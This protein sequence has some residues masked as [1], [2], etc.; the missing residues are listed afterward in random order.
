MG[1]RQTACRACAAVKT[2][3][4]Q[5]VP[6]TRCKRLS[7]PCSLGDP[8]LSSPLPP[9]GRDD[10]EAAPAPAPGSR[11]AGLRARHSK[12]KSVCSNCR[13][14][15]KKC[16]ERRP[17]CSDC[18]RLGLSCSMRS[19]QHP[20]ES[21]PPQ[22][23]RHKTGFS[24]RDYEIDMA[25]AADPALD[26][27]DFDWLSVI[28]E[29]CRADSTAAA[30]SLAHSSALQVQ[31]PQQAAPTGLAAARSAI[32][33]TASA[34]LAGI[35]PALL[36]GWEVGE[37]HLLNHFLQ[38]V[39]RSLTLVSD[40]ENPL[41]C[42]VVPLALANAAMRHALVAL[43]ACHL[44]RTYPNFE[45]DMLRHRSLALQ[46]LEAEL[47]LDGQRRTVLPLAA[48]LLLC[49]LEICAG[50]SRRWLLYL[51]GARALLCGDIP[52]A[53]ERAMELLID[54]HDYLC[55][56]AAV[57]SENVPRPFFPS[58]GLLKP[59]KSGIHPL[60]G[61]AAGLYAILA[62]INQFGIRHHQLTS[63][64]RQSS[65]RELKAEA[66]SI[67]QA[68]EDW[69]PTRDQQGDVKSLSQDMAEARAVASAVQCAAKLLLHDLSR[70]DA[71]GEETSS[72]QKTQGLVDNILSALAFIRPGS[73]MNARMLFPL[74]T[75]GLFSTS[76]AHRLT[77]EFRV[78]LLNASLGFGSIAG[79][80][81]T[82]NV[83]WA[84]A[85][86]GE[87]CQ[88]RESMRSTAPGTVLL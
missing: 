41:I 40:E 29:E 68:L 52:T 67:E 59:G 20:A 38:S 19:E 46:A 23:P 49:L 21:S 75:A 71:E 77:L 83:V 27:P 36:E 61:I 30:T 37:V 53:D 5:Q 57:T 88:W 2:C 9:R 8:S 44:A 63:L 15:H 7:L 3:C 58:L 74:F 42:V 16:D 18:S 17:S 32:L 56:V 24:L 43:S 48:T 25:A 84:R 26:M 65:A 6:C 64:E 22:P 33:A 10:D 28:E 45:S 4:S 50:D 70:N 31:V 35:T 73:P 72:S 87:P 85:N 86:Q 62:Q 82:L 78:N 12:S 69:K 1:R 55:V 66:A 51:R 80:H 39:A 11:A 34:K 14:R 47:E 13:R 79:A 54:L 81:Q 60:L 76:K